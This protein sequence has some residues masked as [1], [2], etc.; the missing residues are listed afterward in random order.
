M[1]KLISVQVLVALI[2]SSVISAIISSVITKINN[3]RNLKLKYITEERQKWRTQ[4]K[5][6]IST[7]ISG[8]HKDGKE[9]EKLIVEVQLSLNPNDEEDKKIVKCL[10]KILTNNND[11]QAKDNLIELIEQLLKHDWE[12][13]K[14]E[15][16]PFNRFRIKYARKV[17]QI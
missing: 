10:K 3:D 12:R 7:I 5:D 1:D 17:I 9:L 8:S 14:G 15:A 11:V 13:A 16:S 4:I 2:S 6:K